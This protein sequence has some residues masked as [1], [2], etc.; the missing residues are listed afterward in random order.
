MAAKL[1]TICGGTG[2]VLITAAYECDP[3][4]S[5]CGTKSIPCRGCGGSGYIPIQSKE[6]SE[7]AA[8]LK[9]VEEVEKDPKGKEA[10]E[11]AQ[12]KYGTLTGEDLQKRF[13][14]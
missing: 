7:L 14:I 4:S 12:R 10:M 6:E 1:C 9:I 2:K 11:E 3:L 5:E 13:T 8:F